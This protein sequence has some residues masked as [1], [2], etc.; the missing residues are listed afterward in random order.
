MYIAKIRYDNNNIDRITVSGMLGLY[1]IAVI[2]SNVHS[3]HIVSTILA[4]ELGKL[5]K[6][7]LEISK[8]S[9]PITIEKVKKKWL[10]NKSRSK[11]NI[12]LADQ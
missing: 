8:L 5:N 9:C 6:V 1:G 11:Y 3:N 4:D 7:V 10:Y 12:G 2:K